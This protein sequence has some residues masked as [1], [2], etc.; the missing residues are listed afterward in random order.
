M[1]SQAS[2]LPSA[3]SPADTQ[4]EPAAMQLSSTQGDPHALTERSPQASLGYASQHAVAGDI[5]MFMDGILHDDAL[6]ATL[7]N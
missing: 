5:A 4:S 1:L 2:K 7:G 3:L 6:S